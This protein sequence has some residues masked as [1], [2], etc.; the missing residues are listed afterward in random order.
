MTRETSER[1]GFRIYACGQEDKA[2]R[3]CGFTSCG[4]CYVSALG[5]SR[6]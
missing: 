1:S 3:P 2:V 5:R 6:K 4:N